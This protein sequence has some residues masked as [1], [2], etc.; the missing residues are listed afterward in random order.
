VSVAVFY[1]E[2]AIGFTGIYERNNKDTS[3]AKEVVKLLDI[4][5]KVKTLNIDEAKEMLAEKREDDVALVDVREPAEYEKG[6]IPGAILIPLSHIMD[7]LKELDPL[8]TTITYC[9]KGPRSKSAALFMEEHGFRQV[10]SLNGG[11]AAWNGYIA[12]GQFDAGMFLIEG[13]NTAEELIALAW[14]LEA[15]T[16]FFY[17]QIKDIVSDA[18]TKQIF[19]L[20]VKAEERHKKTIL[21]TYKQITGTGIADEILKS[22]SATGI[23]ESGISSKEAITWLKEQDRTLQDILEFSMQLEINSLDLYIKILREIEDEVTEEVFNVIV[24]EEK[25]HLSR[26]GKLLDS[27]IRAFQA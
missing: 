23:L 16:K 5:K 22:E 8:K 13:K 24:K 18:E 3:K 25:V 4:F 1:G 19:E 20:F 2:T 12:S 11:V 27:N 6:H 21:E 9:A 26:L 7:K 10:F 15:E 17:G 14:T